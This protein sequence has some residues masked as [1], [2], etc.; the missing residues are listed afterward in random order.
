MRRIIAEYAII[1]TLGAI[2]YGLLE[3]L[4]RGY[5]HWSM[6][7]AGGL[8]FMIIY[9]MNA[10][11]AGWG[12]YKK[13]MVGAL[14]VTTVEFV[15]GCIVNIALGWRVWDYSHMPFSVMGQVCLTFCVLWFLLCLPILA[16]SELLQ[17]KLFGYR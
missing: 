11:R 12:L 4:W 5:T 13:C 1:Y 7:V 17:K 14:V 6:T 8:C 3:L 15:L 2:G 9:G 10:K 16:V